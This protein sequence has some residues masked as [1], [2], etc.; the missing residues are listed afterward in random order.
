MLATFAALIAAFTEWNR[1]D[2]SLDA[3]ESPELVAAADEPWP[4]SARLS[5]PG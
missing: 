1:G 3:A 5:P 4:A 2:E